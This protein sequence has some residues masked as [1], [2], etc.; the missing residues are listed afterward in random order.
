MGHTAHNEQLPFWFSNAAGDIKTVDR[1]MQYLQ[2][3]L[4]THVVIGSFTCEARPERSGT[5]FNWL[6][7]G[8]TSNCLGLPNGGEQYLKDHL[9]QM[10]ELTA[11]HNKKLVV[12]ATG[13][14]VRDIIELSM[15][16]HKLAPRAIIEINLGCPNRAGK[17]KLKP[18]IS[19]NRDTVAR[20]CNQLTHT[21]PKDVV[22]YVKLSP[23]LTSH[24]RRD[25]ANIIYYTTARGIVTINTVPNVR[26]V[27]TDGAPLLTFGSG[28]GGMGG[29][30]VSDLAFVN[31]KHFAVLAPPGKEVISVGGISTAAE[32]DRRL[33][34]GCKGVQIASAIFKA[35]ENAPRA[36]YEIGMEWAMCHDMAYA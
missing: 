2:V 17:G 19:K 4:T 6:P 36:L 3:P 10:Y 33:Q 1:L 34:A 9:A 8:T 24:A 25:L 22:W 16:V 32:I 21:F 26:L 7:D 35:G 13:D 12:S 29:S 11:A 5:V 14:S 28:H 23:E 30:A 15:L 20:V 31:S 18:P 27:D